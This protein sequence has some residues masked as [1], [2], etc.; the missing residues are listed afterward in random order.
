MKIGQ[1]RWGEVEGNGV[2][3]RSN[4]RVCDGEETGVLGWDVVAVCVGEDVTKRM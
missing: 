2:R 4:E 1:G 3:I